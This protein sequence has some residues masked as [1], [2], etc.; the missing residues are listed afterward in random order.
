MQAAE[1]A[2]VGIEP[3]GWMFTRSDGQPVHPHSISQTFE[4]IARRAGVPII[5]LHDMR[6]TAAT[7]L[8]AAGAPVKVV[9]ERLGHANSTFTIETYQHVLPGMQA[10]AARTPSRRSSPASAWRRRGLG[11]PVEH[12]GDHHRNPVEHPD[13]DIG[14][15]L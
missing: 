12:P 2:A 1:F 7:L 9:S 8:I 5:R 4:R 10:D 14:P 6:H 15:G 3:A 13:N 11:R